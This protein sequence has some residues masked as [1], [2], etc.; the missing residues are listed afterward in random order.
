MSHL[1]WATSAEASVLVIAPL[2]WTGSGQNST[3]RRRLQA[4]VK[5]G[6]DALAAR[7]EGELREDRVLAPVVVADERLDLAEG[8]ARLEHGVAD[9][10]GPA[11]DRL[12]LA[13]GRVQ[14]SRWDLGR[15]ARAPR[16]QLCLAA[17]ESTRRACR[18]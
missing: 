15:R 18:G 7:L 13:D 4:Y 8:L 11:H 9:V 14:P 16:A 3:A 5:G 12:A 6:L 17:R 10:G 1:S 2:G